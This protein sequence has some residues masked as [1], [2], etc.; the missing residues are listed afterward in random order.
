[1]EEDPIF[2]DSLQGSDSAENR[3]EGGGRHLFRGEGTNRLVSGCVD[4]CLGYRGWGGAVGREGG[5]REK[6][7]VLGRVL[8]KK[9]SHQ[10][11]DLSV[12]GW[13]DIDQLVRVVT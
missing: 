8:S 12:K 10:H 4:V 2:G 9:Q 13:P 5:R 6:A 7:V 3:I 11:R 1:M